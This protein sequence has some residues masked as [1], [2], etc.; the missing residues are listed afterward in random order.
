MDAAAIVRLHRDPLQQEACRKRAGAR[1]VSVLRQS[2]LSEP[3]SPKVQD[4]PTSGVQLRLVQGRGPGD[5]VESPYVAEARFRTKRRTTW[6]GYMV[7]LTE[8]C[9]AD[10]PPSS[11]TPTPPRRMCTR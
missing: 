8:T 4:D 1:V 7:H 10:A 9:D 2:P 3:D 5:R 6:I 11:C